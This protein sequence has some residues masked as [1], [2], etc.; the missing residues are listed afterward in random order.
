ML[1]GGEFPYDILA[2]QRRPG[3][4]VGH[5][6]RPQDSHGPANPERWRRAMM[7]NAGLS[8]G[9]QIVPGNGLHQQTVITRYPVANCGVQIQTLRTFKAFHAFRSAVRAGSTDG[10]RPVGMKVAE[11]A[12]GMPA[13]LQGIRGDAPER[14]A[15]CRCSKTTR[16][17][18]S[19]VLR[20][21]W[22]IT[23]LSRTSPGTT[24]G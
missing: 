9:V 7:D 4:A 5:R 19:G 13:M 1:E 21:A 2:W 12:T 6:S 3:Y 17:R 8:A 23:L 22:M 16:L 14:S 11:D 20:S 10:N 24:I 15:V 18:L